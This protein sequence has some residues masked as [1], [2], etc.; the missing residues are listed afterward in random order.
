MDKQKKIAF[1]IGSLAKG[2]A[3]RV[4]VNLAEYFQ[5]AGYSVYIVTK[6]MEQ[7]E[8]TVF[9]GI[10]RIVADI[11]KEQESSSRI[12]NFYKRVQ[13]LR[14]VWKEI[15]PDI[16]VSF[17]K[18]NNFM[19][20]L[21]SRGLKIPVFV[22][23]RSASFREYPGIYRYIANVL[24]PMAAG[25]IVQ[26]PEAR[27]YFNKQVRN[28]TVILPNSLRDEFVTE[29]ISKNRRNEIVTVGR[30]DENKNQQML[31]HAFARI[32][33]KFPQTQVI[34]YGDGEEREKLGQLIANKNLTSR[35]IMAGQQ[36]DIK[37]KIKAARIFVL[38]SR[39]EGIPNAVMEAMALGVVPISTDFGGGGVK[40][41]IQDGEDGFIVPVDDVEVLAQKLDLLLSDSQLEKNM[42]EKA[43][44][45]R[46]RLNPEKVN[47]QW[48]ETF[49]RYLL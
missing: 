28:K 48:K 4:I 36:S 32:A 20:I 12:Q 46:E 35:V 29:P 1:Y 7:D 2:G 21:S 34:I 11:T 41:L 14:K 9:Y 39:V 6:L 40:Q 45:I 31:I 47:R 30:L 42:R 26:T 44:L 22:A 19:A 37:D 49:E 43:L 18:K 23:V 38:T 5:S 10:T 3:E 27:D 24:F 8:Y 15:A 17:I 13:N 16:I 33:D 25:V